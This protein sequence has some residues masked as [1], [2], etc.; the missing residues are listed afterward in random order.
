MVQN[1]D[2]LLQAMAHSRPVHRRADGTA[3]L[4]GGR[5]LLSKRERHGSRRWP[6]FRWQ[7]SGSCAGA[8]GSLPYLMVAPWL[9][10]LQ[11]VGRSWAGARLNLVACRP[12]L[13]SLAGLDG[14][15]RQKGKPLKWWWGNQR[16]NAKCSFRRGAGFESKPTR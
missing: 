4:E 6:R 7:G 8:A 1:R 14:D 11:V 10:N 2:Q 3:R 9:E 16:V 15:R 13:V 5:P 12:G